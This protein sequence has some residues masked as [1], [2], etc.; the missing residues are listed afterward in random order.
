MLAISTCRRT[1]G[2]RRLVI[3]AV[4]RLGSTETGE[5]IYLLRAER[6]GTL[7]RDEKINECGHDDRYTYTR[8][9]FGRKTLHCRQYAS[10]ASRLLVLAQKSMSVKN[11]TTIV[12]RLRTFRGGSGYC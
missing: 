12:S 11:A 9:L 1:N 8:K 10:S 4:W 3:L 7:L 6:D 5:S 2:M